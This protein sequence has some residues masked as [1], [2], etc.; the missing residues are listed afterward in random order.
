[1]RFALFIARRYLHKGGKHAFISTISWVSALGITIGVAAL[2]I[3]LALINGFQGDLRNKLLDATAHVMV[4]QGFGDGIEGYEPLMDQILREHSPMVQSISPVAYGTVLVRG[5]GRKSG[6][7]VLRGIRADKEETAAWQRQLTD[8]SLPE[9]DDE[10]MIG[11]DLAGRLGLFPGDRCIIMIPT[12][13]MSPGGSLPKMKRMTV[14]G[15]YKSGIYEVDNT[16]LLMPL[17]AAQALFR[18][19]GKVH[20]LR[21]YLHDINDAEDLAAKLRESLSAELSIITWKDLNSSLYSALDLEKTVLFFTLTLIIIV[22]S[23]NI[24]AGLI[25]LVYE[26]RKDIGILASCGT[27]LGV[28]RQIFFLQG[29]IIGL[30][31]T[32]AG[33]VLGSLFCLAANHFEFIKVPAEIYQMSHIPFKIVPQDMLAVITASMLICLTAT[34]FPSRRAARINIIEAVKNE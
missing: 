5:E 32:T 10:L 9:K 30:I 1:M 28:I 27:P 24:V 21:L 33:A 18:M 14:S 19:P 26:K 4:S 17:P 8:G 16:T 2:V 3:A 11:K 34:L 31:G 29:G 7:A 15:I 20:Y 6:G 25:L 23:L 12:P 13:V 22:A